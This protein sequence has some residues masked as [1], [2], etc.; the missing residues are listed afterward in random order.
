MKQAALGWAFA[1]LATGSSA[2]MEAWSVLDRGPPVRMEAAGSQPG[3]VFEAL[4]DKPE[5]AEVQP[6][7]WL[8]ERLE[9]PLGAYGQAQQCQRAA[10]PRGVAAAAVCVLDGDG[11]PLI[12]NVNAVLQPDNMMLQRIT[13]ISSPDPQLIQ[14]HGTDIRVLIE[15]AQ[16]GRLRPNTSEAQPR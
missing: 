10:A 14:S 9:L 15:A 1:L 5:L 11:M 7:T 12:A 4:I 16:A 6:E 8:A 2:Q 3:L 13:F